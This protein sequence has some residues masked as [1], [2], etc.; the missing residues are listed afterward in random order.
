MSSAARSARPGCRRRRTRAPRRCRAQRTDAGTR[1]AP[2]CAALRTARPG[3]RAHLGVRRPGQRRGAVP[4]GQPGPA[5]QRREGGADLC[6][7]HVDAG[8]IGCPVADHRVHLGARRRAVLR[9]CRLV[10]AV[11]PQQPRRRR[12]C[13][14]HEQARHSAQ[15]A[16]RGQVEPG[17][18]SPA[19]VVCTCASTN[20]GTTSAPSRSTT[21]SGVP[22]TATACSPPI[23]AIVEPSIARAWP[24]G[25]PRCARARCAAGSGT[26]AVRSPASPAAARLAASPDRRNVAISVSIRSVHLRQ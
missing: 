15:R 8:E 23:Q 16:R 13:R 14:G 6:R 7:V 20:P 2:L 4:A 17:Q 22:A 24:P 5:G 18:A 12:A 10:P 26:S 25:R 3:E 1:A 21:R 11:P 19:S 9:P